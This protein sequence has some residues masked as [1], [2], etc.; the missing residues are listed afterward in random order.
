[1]I[2]ILVADDSALMRLSLER[3]LGYDPEINI[4]AFCSNGKEVLEKLKTI[5]PDVIALDIEMPKMNGLEVL[6]FIMTTNPIPVVIISSLVSEGAEE[7]IRALELG[8]IDLIEKSVLT[9][10]NPEDLCKKIKAASHAKVLRRLSIK[11]TGDDMRFLRERIKNRAQNIAKEI[12][13]RD[14]KPVIELDHIS[15]KA[16]D[17]ENK[18]NFKP[19]LILL[20]IST[21]GPA[22]L[23][24]V[25]PELSPS[26]S[27]M[28]VAQHM[29]QGFTKSLADRLNNISKVKVKEAEDGEPLEKGKVLIA[30]SGFQTR[31][32]KRISDYYVRITD[33]KDKNHLYKPCIDIL[34]SSAANLYP[35]SVLGIIMTGMGNDG[36]KGCID[37][38]N[39]EGKVF[40]QSEETCVIPTMPNSVI[41]AGI[42]DRIYSL[43]YMSK[44]LNTLFL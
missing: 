10:G 21:G 41:K 14:Y 26:I 12:K 32:Y 23:Q 35:K 42:V 34:F 31:V 44:A 18:I 4:V 2:D 37:I 1:M 25:I 9:H 20:G 3:M 40:V 7:T 16:D 29:P 6:E 13:I 33:E 39:S 36:T 5:R 28:I 15:L 8:A 30:P 17:Q 24:K 19:E 27:P 43:E 38:H 11:P 22:S